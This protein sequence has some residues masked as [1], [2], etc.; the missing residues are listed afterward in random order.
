[1]DLARWGDSAGTFLGI[2]MSKHVVVYKMDGFWMLLL[3]LA[4]VC[5]SYAYDDTLIGGLFI[6]LALANVYVYSSVGKIIPEVSD[7]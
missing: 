7:E 6:L 1:M 5:L 3:A 2:W 4:G